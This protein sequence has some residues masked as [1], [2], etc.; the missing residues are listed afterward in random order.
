MSRSPGPK[1]ESGARVAVVCAMPKSRSGAK[2][3]VLICL[4]LLGMDQAGLDAS[5]AIAAI[6]AMALAF[7]SCLIELQ[8]YES[9]QSQL[10]V[11][12]MPLATQS[13]WLKS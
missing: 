9:T 13:T 8:C 10:L 2:C 12:Y 5:A 1:R 4:G 6:A 7:F 3:A 11:C